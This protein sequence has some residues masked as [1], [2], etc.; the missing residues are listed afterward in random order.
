[1]HKISA[2]EIKADRSPSG[3]NSV[4]PRER[5]QARDGLGAGVVS[6]GKSPVSGERSAVAPGYYLGHQISDDDV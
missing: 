1:L 3:G 6:S 2:V 5:G 4:C